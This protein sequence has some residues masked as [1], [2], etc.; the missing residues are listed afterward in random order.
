MVELGA[1]AGRDT[2]VEAVRDRVSEAS[3]L[4]TQ[5]LAASLAALAVADPRPRG[6]VVR[7]SSL[8]WKGPMGA[9]KRLAL[10][11][12]RAV[13]A[14]AA[15]QDTIR[16][17]WEGK[18][19]V[20]GAQVARS[21]ILMDTTSSR[22]SGLGISLSWTLDGK[23]GPLPAALPQ[24]TEF[25]CHAKIRN[26]LDR[27]VPNAAFTLW[28]PSGW[29]VRNDRLDKLREGKSSAAG[30]YRDIR[31]DRVV[32]YFDLKPKEEREVVLPIQAVQAGS[33]Q[34]PEAVVEALYDEHI[35]ARVRS[36][37]VR[38]ESAGARAR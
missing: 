21:G 34:G 5:E 35:R 30:D 16:L 15:D 18:G 20:V 37:R 26:L 13:V 11:G 10:R 19:R 27:R 25:V 17:K 1:I 3:W 33:Y 9:W 12:G 36:P 14:L 22:D 6:P 2:L 24:R 7:D 28:L 31:D 32:E 4:S 29:E 38:V 8:W 23:A